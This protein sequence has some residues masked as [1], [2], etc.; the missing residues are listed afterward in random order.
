[1]LIE[2]ANH[3]NQFVYIHD[4]DLEHGCDYPGFQ[5]LD[6]TT[7][8]EAPNVNM[9]KMKNTKKKIKWF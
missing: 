1:M 6:T 2:Q 7:S 9:L 4:L 8:S 3:E 5:A